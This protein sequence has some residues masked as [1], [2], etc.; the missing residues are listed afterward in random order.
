MS[1]EIERKFLVVDD[2]W[3]AAVRES[4]PLCQGYLND[5]RDCSVRV[6]ISG[7]RAWLNLKSVTLG[8]ERHEFEYEIPLDDARQM[9]RVLSRK[10]IIEKTRHFVEVGPHTWEVDVFEGE[11]AG[12]VVAEIELETPD[13][14]FEK[15]SWVGEEVTFDPRYYN[16][17]LATRPFRSWRA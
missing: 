4:V 7:Q 2:S 3:R 13:Q 15:P 9:L 5:E 12:L 1:L 14:P 10:P 8:A 17:N 11:N 16:T 6:R